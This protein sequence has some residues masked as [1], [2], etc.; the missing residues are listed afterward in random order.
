MARL[1]DRERAWSVRRVPHRNGLEHVPESIGSFLR[2][3]NART[4][5]G[6]SPARKRA[7][8]RRHRVSFARE[9]KR[10]SAEWKIMQGRNA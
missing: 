7:Y 8:E 1:G 9:V 5:P 4:A 2:T 3:A 10:L 6:V